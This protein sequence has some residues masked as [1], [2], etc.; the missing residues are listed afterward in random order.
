MA[1]DK[2]DG[3]PWGNQVDPDEA[4]LR[5]QAG[6]AGSGLL[7]GQSQAWYGGA[8]ETPPERQAEVRR[9]IAELARKRLGPDSDTVSDK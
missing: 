9:A 6:S 5:G 4:Y 2:L 3:P 8:L 7:S 1:R